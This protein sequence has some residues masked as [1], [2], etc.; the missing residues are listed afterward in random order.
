MC[1]NAKKRRIRWKTSNR[2]HFDKAW[3]GYARSTR[4]MPITM[5]C[6]A[7]LAITTAQPFSPPTPPTK[8][9]N[10]LSQAS[11]IHVREGRGAIQPPASTRP[12]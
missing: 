2:L 4:S 9:L 11:Y 8:L 5:P 12:T 10:A 1:Y 3:Y 7:N 6:A